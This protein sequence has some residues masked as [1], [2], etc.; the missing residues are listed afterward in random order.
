MNNPYEFATIRGTIMQQT[1]EGADDHIDKMS[2]KYLNIERY[3]F[4]KSNETRLIL[5][6]NP[7]RVFHMSIPVND[8]LQ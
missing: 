8:F 7:E 5:K 6:I 1:T 4:R 3:P 2:K